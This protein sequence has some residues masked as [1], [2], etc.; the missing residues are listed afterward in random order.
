MLLVV[1]SALSE[2]SDMHQSSSYGPYSSTKAVHQFQAKSLQNSNKCTNSLCWPPA[3]HTS[4]TK[5]SQ[6]T[7]VS[8]QHLLLRAGT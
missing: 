8:W 7:H 3:Y 1:K 6:L 4:L 2:G 5:L